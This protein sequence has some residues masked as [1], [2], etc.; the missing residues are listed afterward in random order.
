MS[1]FDAWENLIRSKVKSMATSADPAHDYLHFQRVVILAKRIGQTEKAN[2]EIVMPAAWLHDFVNIP[3]NDP[4]RSQASQLSADHA[5][6]YLKFINY[7]KEYFPAIHHAIVAHSFSADIPCETLEA[8]VLQDADRLDGL[9][10]IGI[11]RC[12]ATSGILKR[13]LYSEEDPLCEKRNPDDQTYS[14]DHFFK[15]LFKISEKLHTKEA[16]RI[17]QQRVATMKEY[18]RVLNQEISG[19]E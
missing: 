14:L 9:G 10:A 6:E 3:K 12:F 18:I 13:G 7:D 11:A 8:K 2:M 1:N 19:K 5:I 15:K 4:R 16:K 17:G